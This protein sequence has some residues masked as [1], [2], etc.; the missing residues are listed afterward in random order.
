MIFLH[1]CGRL[2]MQAFGHAGLFGHAGV[3]ACS[4]LPA[5]AAVGVEDFGALRA[6]KMIVIGREGRADF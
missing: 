6:L 2:G 4:S 5:A 1:K 3:W